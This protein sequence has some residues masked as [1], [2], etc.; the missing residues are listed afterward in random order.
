MARIA[1]VHH[2]TNDDVDF[3]RN[4]QVTANAI[5]SNSPA[6]SA[7]TAKVRRRE[8]IAATMAAT[9]EGISLGQIDE[10]GFDESSHEKIAPT[11]RSA[12][13]TGNPRQ[14]ERVDVRRPAHTS[15]DPPRPEPGGQ[16]RNDRRVLDRRKQRAQISPMSAGR[17]RH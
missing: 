17:R 11:H 12:G 1:K 6:S 8:L 7:D 10:I 9:R 16:A 5:A 2:A 4:N 13:V 15:P 3:S 14:N